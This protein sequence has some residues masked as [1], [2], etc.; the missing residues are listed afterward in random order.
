MSHWER[1]FLEERPSLSLSLFRLAVAATVGLHVIPTFFQMADNYLSGAFREYNPSFFPLSVLVWVDQSPDWLVWAMC[2][3]FLLSWLAFLMGLFTQPSGILMD[4]ACYYFYARNSLHIGTLSWDILLVTLFLVLATVYP[5]DSFSLD[6][7]IRADPEPWRRRRPF[8]IQRLLQLQ[9]ASTYFFTGLAKITGEGNWLGDNPYYYLM[10]APALGVIKEFP[11]RWFLAAQPRL[12]WLIGLGVIACELNMWWL[13][14]WRRTRPW[15]IGLGFFFHFLLL[16]TMHVPTIFFFLFPPQL[17]LFIDPETVVGWIEARRRGWAERGRDKLIF[18]GECGFCRASLARILALDPFGR[19]EPV[20]F[21]SVNVK[22]LHPA[23]SPELCH[24]RIQFLEAGGRLSSGFDAFRRLSLRL[25]LAW[26][27][28]LL[29]NIPGLGLV[30][31]PV[32]DWVSR[33][34]IYLIV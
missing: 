19:I 8:F 4:L 24:A 18:D 11:W 27:L 29:F 3:V 30:G 9:L 23:L 12:C 32:Y 10:N 5:G 1:W 25:P 6:S 22:A 7:L 28:A 20:D 34:R 16:A 13:L 2:G 26:P 17:L 21:H 15:A 33:N 14:F 31:E